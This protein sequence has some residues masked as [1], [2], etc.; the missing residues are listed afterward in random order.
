M[1]IAKQLTETGS[2]LAKLPLDPRIGRMLIAARGEGCL[3]Q[4][5]VIASALSV[6]DPRVRPMDNPAAADERHRRFADERSDFLAFIKLWQLFD[7][8]WEKACRENS[9]S[10]PRMREWRDVHSQLHATVAELGWRVSRADPAR[11]EG[12][13][14]IRRALLTGLLGNVGLRLDWLRQRMQQALS[15]G[16]AAAAVAHEAL[17]TGRTIREVVIAQGFV[18]RGAISAE[19]LDRALDVLAMA[20]PHG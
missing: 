20:R 6:Q 18:D 11:P 15:A 16:D 2:E 5:L 3:E 1:H 17:A 8:K 7:G 9:L 13:R 14:A 12:Y 10:V 4:V 19:D